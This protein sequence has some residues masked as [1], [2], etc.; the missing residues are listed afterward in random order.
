MDDLVLN[1][2]SLVEHE[3]HLRRVFQRLEDAG[4][5]LNKDKVTLAASEIRY[6]GHYLSYRGIRVVPE[7]VEAIEGFPPSDNLKALRRFLGMAN[8][9]AKFI[10]RFSE[11]AAPLHALKR[12]GV[13]FVWGD[14]RRL[15]LIH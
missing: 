14:E 1:S 10:P 5:T 2:P 7:R 15:V 8:F 11:R 4:F 9:C 12:T 3:R 13:R 6:L